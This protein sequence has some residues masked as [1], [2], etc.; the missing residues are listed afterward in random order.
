M[1]AE[2][3]L[4]DK[5]AFLNNRHILDCSQQCIA[6]HHK[7]LFSLVEDKTGVTITHCIAGY[8]D[9]FV[10]TWFRSLTAFNHSPVTHH[11]H[12]NT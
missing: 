12:T 9:Y 5:T 2:S 3:A 10:S 4:Q 11:F 8:H 7:N 6:N 1:S